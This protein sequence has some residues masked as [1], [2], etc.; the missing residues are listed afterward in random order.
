MKATRNP[1]QR[2]AMC[3]FCA[4]AYPTWNYSCGTGD[5]WPDRW[6]ACPT[7]FLL[8]EFDEKTMLLTRACERIS[9][10]QK[11]LAAAHAV[12]WQYRKGPP[13]QLA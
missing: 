3:D 4:S 7:C 2:A 9:A 5:E 1:S 6:R 13:V 12:F 8:I 10:P 11:I